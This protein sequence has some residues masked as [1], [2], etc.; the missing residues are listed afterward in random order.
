MHYT[1]DELMRWALTSALENRRE[2]IA[3][4]SV[5]SD[6][7]LRSETQ[8]LIDTFAGL[9][10]DRKRRLRP[11][12]E[13]MRLACLYGEIDRQTYIESVCAQPHQAPDSRAERE[14]EM[15]QALHHMRQK[16]WGLTG[17]EKGLLAG[18]ASDKAPVE[19]VKRHALKTNKRK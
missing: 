10:A 3:D 12:G 15:L 17:L 13:T 14:M 1:Q 4:K 19:P 6:E 7:T 9:L 18:I 16:A 11:R 5:W 2:F 8:R